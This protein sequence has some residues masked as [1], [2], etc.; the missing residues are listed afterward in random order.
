MMYKFEYERITPSNILE[1]L[2]TSLNVFFT[3]NDV[4]AA[5]FL[6]KYKNSISHKEIYFCSLKIQTEI[7]T[8]CILIEAFIKLNN[9]TEKIFFVS[10]VVTRDKYRKKGFLRLLLFEVEKYSNS[11]GASILIVIARRSVSDLYWKMGFQGFSHFPEFNLLENNF[12]LRSAN[13]RQVDNN[14]LELLREAH[15]YSLR[16]SNCRIIR[17]ENDW[18]RIISNQSETSYTIWS[19]QGREVKNYAIFS[20]STLIEASTIGSK[21][22]LVKFYLEVIR[23]AKK[24]QLDR[25]HPISKYLNL[26]LWTYSERFE[27]REGHLFKVLNNCSPVISNFLNSIILDSSRTRLEISPLDQ[28]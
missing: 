23:N 13:L 3:G 5:E 26:E 18:L 19:L 21:S 2:D 16:S 17:S 24:I 27:P 9:S 15:F 11:K 8:S 22:Q 7:V 6:S 12:D 25:F 4:R 14:D 10:Q 28:W 20:G 1:F